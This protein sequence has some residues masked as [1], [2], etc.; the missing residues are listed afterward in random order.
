MCD[1]FQ[2]CFLCIVLK[3]IR[4]S[5]YLVSFVVIHTFKL[6]S[7]INGISKIYSIIIIK[8]IFILP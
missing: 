4:G 2:F 3:F 1:R 5:S 8:N 7:M 6:Q